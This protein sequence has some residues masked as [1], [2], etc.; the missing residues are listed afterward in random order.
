MRLI[1]L[2]LLGV[3]FCASA[4]TL[5]DGPYVFYKG[6]SIEVLSV[7]DGVLRRSAFLPTPDYRLEL[8]VN[9]REHTEWNFTVN[10]QDSLRVEPSEFPQPEKMLV[11]SDVEG[12]F[13]A[14]RKLMIANDV[15]NEQYQW[16]FGKGHLVICGDLFDRG[17][18]VT[19]FLWLL[20]KLEPEARKAGGYVHVILGNHDI[21][22]LGG[23][24]R[25]VQP[26]YMESADRMGTEYIYLYRDH[27][28]LGR[29]LRTKNIVEKIGRGLY[30]HAGISPQVLRLGLTASKI[31]AL[32][33]PYYDKSQ[34]RIVYQDTTLAAL[35]DGNTSPFWYRGY[36][37]TTPQTERLVDE[38][39]KF[40]D[41]GLIAV[42]HTIVYDN[43]SFYFGRKVLGLDVDQHDGDHQAVLWE[44]DAWYKV[45]DRGEKTAVPGK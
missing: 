9:F 31:N 23:D 39:C 32:V 36:F 1:L 30:L 15:M 14:F 44:N 10:L 22:N 13:E 8:P 19:E 27:S 6:D 37:A 21:M 11:L 33:R 42:G 5:D 29:W 20:Y 12:E 43:I 7:N 3:T 38:T 41:V 35:F 24:V 25:Y 16:T 40:F 4:Q 26:K 45:N 2:F 28:E 17:E 34:T 18:Q